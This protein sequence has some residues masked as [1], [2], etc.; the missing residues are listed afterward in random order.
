MTQINLDPGMLK[1]LAKR[2]ENHPLYQS[3][4]IPNHTKRVE[5]VLNGFILEDYLINEKLELVVKD[6]LQKIQK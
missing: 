1:E 4:N 2:L 5:T 6:V 3:L